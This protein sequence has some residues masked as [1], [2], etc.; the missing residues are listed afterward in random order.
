MTPTFVVAENTCRYVKNIRLDS[1][2]YHSHVEPGVGVDE[3][4]REY[5][6]Y[7]AFANLFDVIGE[8][9]EL[10]CHCSEDAMKEVRLLERTLNPRVASQTTMPEYLD[11]VYNPETNR[12]MWHNTYSKPAKD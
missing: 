5:T 9:L 6:V 11:F 8:T 10:F 7:E 1:R 12:W 4:A 3:E 2:G